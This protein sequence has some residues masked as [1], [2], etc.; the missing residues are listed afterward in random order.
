ML[1]KI[2][3]KKD[4]M[5]A[6]V[7]GR[8]HQEELVNDRLKTKQVKFYYTIKKNK[9]KTFSTNTSKISSKTGKALIESMELIL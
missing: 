7:I 9:L 8:K 1:T 3:M 2:F 5:N 4:L 6:E